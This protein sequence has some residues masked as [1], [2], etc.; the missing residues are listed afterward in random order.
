M[1]GKIERFEDL[2]VYKSAV[3]CAKLIYSITSNGQFNKDF[4]LRDQIRRAGVSI[5]SNIAEAMNETATK[6]SVIF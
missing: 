5:F 2:E 6:S 4:V 3:A 1:T